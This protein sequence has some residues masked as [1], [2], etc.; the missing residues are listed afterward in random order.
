MQRDCSLLVYSSTTNKHVCI[1]WTHLLQAPLSMCL[2]CVKKEKHTTCSELLFTLFVFVI[3]LSADCKQKRLSH[4]S[5]L[6]KV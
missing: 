5:C 3:E 6:L 1:V 2:V 4:T